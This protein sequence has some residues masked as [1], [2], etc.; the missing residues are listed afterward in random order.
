MIE[1]DWNGPIV[2]WLHRV[3]SRHFVRSLLLD[4]RA[5]AYL[6][7][8]DVET[9]KRLA[10]EL[11]ARFPFETWRARSPD[12]PDSETER[13]RYRSIQEA[14]KAAGV[15]TTSTRTRIS[16]WPLTTSCTKTWKA[17]HRQPRRA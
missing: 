15:A 2:L 14:L 7:T 13:N 6:R 17:R 8:G 11:N 16:A 12:D 10:A 5:V 1:K 3:P 9:A 4:R